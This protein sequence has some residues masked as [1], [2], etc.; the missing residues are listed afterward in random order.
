MPLR[1]E[2]QLRAPTARATNGGM[3]ERKTWRAVWSS[4]LAAKFVTREQ[5]SERAPAPR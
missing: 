3:D 4:Q 2:N 1:S 5:V